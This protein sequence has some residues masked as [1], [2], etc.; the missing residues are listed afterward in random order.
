MNR[1][2][3]FSVWT[4]AVIIALFAAVWFL[5]PHL[6]TLVLTALMA[7]LFY[8]VFKKLRRGKG[9]FAAW[10]TMFISLLV[11]L[12]PIAIILTTAITQLGNLAEAAGKPDAWRQPP[13]AL[14]DAV[15]VANSILEPLTGERPSITE[16]NVV[17]YLQKT[18]PVLAEAL[19]ALL[20]GVLASIP[21]VAVAFVIYTFVFVELL[22]RGP[23][24]VQKL[25]QLSP[26]NEENTN[27]YI[28]RVSMMTNAMVKGQLMISM[29]I[30]AISAALL[31]PLGYGEYFFILFLIFTILNFIPLGC[32]IVLVPIVIY[33][34]ATGQFWMGLLVFILYYIAGYLDPVLRPRFIPKKIQLS[35]GITIVATFCGIAYFGLL[36][37]VYGPIITIL[38]MTTID[39]YI[40]NKSSRTPATKTA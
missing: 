27:L 40:K 4:I 3:S 16:K 18:V 10:G 19:A 33:S 1:V 6:W 29:I 38:I 32:G 26:L 21:A 28:E 12:I 9:Y 15:T 7:Y 25:K 36:G 13:A 34:M 17:E 37:V 35:T 31:I 39:F 14:Q 20:L 22:I 24:L 8:P 11:V 23:R 30:S 2:A 5:W